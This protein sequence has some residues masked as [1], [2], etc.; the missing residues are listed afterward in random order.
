MGLQRAVRLPLIPLFSRLDNMSALRLC[1][2]ALLLALL[3][4]LWMNSIILTSFLYCGA[5]SCI[6]CSRWGHN[7]SFDWLAG[8]CLVQSKKWFPLSA[9]RAHY[10]LMPPAPPCPFL[11]SCSPATLPLGCAFV[12]HCSIPGQKSALTFAEFHFIDD[13]QMKNHNCFLSHVSALASQFVTSC[14][15]FYLQN[16]QR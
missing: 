1:L 6:Q 7:S 13:C 4:P 8:L 14:L 16:A 9:A 11:L 15:V 5:Q 2:S 10:W 12:W 3:T